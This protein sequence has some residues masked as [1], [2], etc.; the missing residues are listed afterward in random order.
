MKRLIIYFLLLLASIWV[1]I[2]IHKDP[3]YVLITYQNW[4]LETTLW[5]AILV[6]LLVFLIFYL[7]SRLLRGTSTVS[8]KFGIWLE[9][10][11]ARK[12]NKF[13]YRG[14]CD[15]AEG[16]WKSAEKNLLQGANHNDV[17]LVNYLAAAE[18]AQKRGHFED[19]DNYLRLAHQ[20]AP[21][22]EI[23]IGLSQA[24]L[25]LNAKQWELALATLRHLHQ[26]SPHH[27]YV[28]KLLKSVYLELNDWKN[29]KE[30]LP[31][32]K[33]NKVL[34]SVDFEKLEQLIYMELLKSAVHADNMT[35]VNET[36]SNTPKSLQQQPALLLLYVD[37][38]LKHKQ[39]NLAEPL[40][41]DALKKYWNSYLVARYGL[42]ISEN[43]EKQLSVAESWLKNH[44]DDSALLLCL[45]R[46]CIR[47]QLLEKARQYL[48]TSIQLEPRA[49]TFRELGQLLEQLGDMPKALECY[50]Q[51]LEFC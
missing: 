27:P 47:N 10:R 36:W 17:P 14:L 16:E 49:E 38:L 29:L 33:H 40:L 45:G 18:A 28:L 3:G 25:Q 11:R 31:E 5:F 22:A 2:K 51:G 39:D 43:P 9:E 30:L 1:G 44:P 8:E 6:I 13:T 41:R 20:S 15:L 12:A 46:L 48:L 32:L 19:R 26:L 35:L 23:A 34:S 4:S 42:I 24:Q 7:L 37:F 50:R 21:Q